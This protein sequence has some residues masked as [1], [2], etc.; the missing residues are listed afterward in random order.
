SFISDK[1]K[2][3]VKDKKK[4]PKTLL[5]PYSRFTKLIIYHLRSKHNFHPRTGSPLYIPDEDSVLRNLKFVAKGVKYK[6][7]G[8]S[9]PDAL[10]TNNIRNAPY[11]FEYLEMVAKHEKRVVAKQTSQGEPAV[12]EPSTPKA[13]KVTKPKAAKQS[14]QTVPKATKPTIHKAATPSKPTSSQP[15]KPKP[16]PTKPSKA[17]PKKKLKLVKETPD[18]PSPATRSKG[19]LVRKRRK[20]KSPLKL[21]DE[22]DDEGP[23]SQHENEGIT[24]NNS[25]TESDKAGSN[26]GKQDEDQVG[27]NPE[28]SNA[29]IQQNSKQMD[30]EFTTTAY[31]NIQENLKL[32]TEDQVIHKEP[33][34]N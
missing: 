5:I 26:P 1:K 29:Y 22:F 34:G 20:P 11:Y 21:V 16:T 30:E 13:A 9:I 7:F 17:V 15:P 32:P 14:G 2:Q 28:V 19:G 27:S 8:M 24:M 33:V 4:E 12:L 23:S 31:L 18:K 6:V 3:S 10:I 25:E